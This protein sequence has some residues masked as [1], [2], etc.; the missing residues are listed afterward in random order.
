MI[1]WEGKNRGGVTGGVTK[2]GYKNIEVGLQ[3]GVLWGVSEGGEIYAILIVACI[4]AVSYTRK[5]IVVFPSLILYIGE[6]QDVS[7]IIL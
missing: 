7:P 3:N 5:Y 4:I 1:T 6:Y 2:W